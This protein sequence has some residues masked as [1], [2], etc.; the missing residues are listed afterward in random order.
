[1]GSG[2]SSI[3][4]LLA[5]KLGFQFVDTDQWI[6]E[7]TGM[8]I[9]AIFKRHGEPH[10]RDIETSAL[11]SLQEMRTAARHRR[12]ASFSA[13]VTEAFRELGFVVEL[14]ASEER[15]CAAFPAN[16]RRPLLQTADPAE[17]VRQ[18]LAE[19]RPL[20]QQVA[21]F[22]IDTSHLDHAEVA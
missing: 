12:L 3:G 5:T 21:H 11:T 17:T 19:R 15:F 8:E 16:R 1:M 2:K 14:A 4:R 22:S 6:V 18:M 10:F 9:A 13:R 20:Y 7:Q